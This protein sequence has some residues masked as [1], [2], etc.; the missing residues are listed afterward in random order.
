MNEI[1]RQRNAPRIVGISI[2]IMFLLMTGAVL[3]FLQ[4]NGVF[5][6]RNVYLLEANQTQLRGLHK[7]MDIRILGESVGTVTNMA[8]GFLAGDYEDSEVSKH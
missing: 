8:Y 5:N 1:F 6:K 3:L 4:R 7:S 2:F